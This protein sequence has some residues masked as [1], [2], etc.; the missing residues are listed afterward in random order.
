LSYENGLLLVLGTAFGIVFFDRFAIGVLMPFIVRELE[1]S[2]TEVGL[3]NSAL[4]LSWAI[5]CFLGGR[6]SDKTG[7]RKRYLIA[8]IVAF[9]LCSFMS[10]LATSFG[11]LLA[12][13]LLMGLTEGPAPPLILAIMARASSERRRGFNFGLIQNAFNSLFGQILAPL[14]LVPIA[15]AYDW[16]IAFFAAGVPGLVIAFVIFKY[17]REPA[18]QA[19]QRRTSAPESGELGVVEIV[20]HRNIWLSAVIASLLFGYLTAGT[21]FMPLY[22][23]EVRGLA[24]AQM[25]VL[26]SLI[27]FCI[28]TT[29]AI[30]PALSDRY[31]R[32]PIAVLFSLLGVV[33]P[34]AILYFQGPLWML[35]VLVFVGWMAAPVITL[36]IAA[37]PSDSLPARYHGTA[38][39]LVAGIGEIAGSFVTPT[40][41]GWAADQ[42]SLAAPLFVQIGCAIAAGA[43]A[44]LLRESAPARVAAMA[45][46][47][48]AP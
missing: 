9:S 23:V 3:V 32:K 1:L 21:A 4:A 22:F 24:P 5:A 18:G 46:A 48:G 47:R 44:L 12:A 41:A 16:R 10:G 14:I 25:S 29:G 17:V 11:M 35:G 34:L 31:G 20:R 28:L 15:V 7:R 26:M 45:H 36:A 19:R 40:L 37:V 6:L 2:N 39:G 43:F 27:G 8:A 13:R 33:S 42:T 30:V 38:I